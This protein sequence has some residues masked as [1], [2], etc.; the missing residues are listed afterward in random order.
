MNEQNQP[1]LRGYA[2][3]R[4]PIVDSIGAPAWPEVFPLEKID[5]LRDTVGPRHFSSQMMLEFISEDKARLDPGALRFYEEELD[6]RTAKIGD[7][8]ITGASCY[9]DPSG[10]RKYA[11]AS[12]CVLVYRDDKNRRA[13]IHDIKY[14]AVEDSDLHPLATQCGLVLDFMTMHGARALAIEVNGLGS[15]L[16]EILREVANRRTQPVVVQKIINHARKELRIL[17]AIEPL[18]TTGRLSAHER[19]RTTP[20]LAEMLGWTPLGA[21][22]HDDGLDALAGALRL[23]PMP[24]RPL[25]Q[26]WRPMNARTDFK[27]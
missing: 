2:S 16:P 9:W 25:G 19:I 18:L 11:D 20:L 12:V 26:F 21:G 15:A 14:L 8:R 7:T 1:F 17:D 24:V 23:N 4:L 6:I 27:V 22:G 10:G 13:F 3:M 5:Q